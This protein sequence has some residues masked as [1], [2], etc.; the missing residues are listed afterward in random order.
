[1]QK[2]ALHSVPRSGSTWLGNIINSH[3]QVSFKY[4]PLF[5]YAFKDY[6]NCESSNE[7]INAFFNEIRLSNDEFINQKKGIEKGIIPI[8]KKDKMITH[9]CY[10]EVRYHHILKNMLQQCK[11]VKVVLLIR[12]PLAVLQSW[13]QAPK[14]FKSE[15]GWVFEEEWLDAP[16]KNL[17][18]PEEFNGYNK[19]KE[20]ANLF[21]KHKNDFPN[22]VHLVTYS[23]LLKNITEEVRKIFEFVNLKLGSQT[24][25]FIES[26]ISFTQ[27]DAYSVY[28]KKQ[29]DDSWKQLPGHIIDYI[30]DDLKNTILE[31][32]IRE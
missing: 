14:E 8:L 4:Q 20:A 13:Y 12:N 24:Y 6:L 16:K 18:R 30:T 32:F 2:I 9:T 5:S 1:M 10:K 29:V 15:Y 19:W 27:Q 28:K 17:K 25:K 31:Q 26:S 3:P 23:D 7:K 21:L 11:D 22:R